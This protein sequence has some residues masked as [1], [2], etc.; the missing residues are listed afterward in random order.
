MNFPTWVDLRELGNNKATRSASVWTFVVPIAAKLLESVKDVVD[1][2]I[3]RTHLLFIS[4][5]H[6]AGKCY[7]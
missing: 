1:I 4:A 2:T 5:C 3:L 6:S 7:L